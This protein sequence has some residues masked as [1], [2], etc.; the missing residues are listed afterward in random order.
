MNNRSDEPNSDRAIAAHNVRAIHV[1]S[2]SDQ[3]TE[4]SGKTQMDSD[5]ITPPDLTRHVSTCK[6]RIRTVHN[7]GKKSTNGPL[8]GVQGG[9]PQKPRGLGLSTER[10]NY[11]VNF[12]GADT[13]QQ[14]TSLRTKMF[15]P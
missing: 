2:T 8:H 7:G 10:T 13:A 11:N 4:N 1:D 12:I 5:E 6:S 3:E 14:L 9:W 15:A